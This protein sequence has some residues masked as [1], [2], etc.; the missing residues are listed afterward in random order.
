MKPEPISR[1]SAELPVLKILDVVAQSGVS[2][3]LVHHYR[4]LGLLPEGGS[5]GRYSQRQADLL[6]HVRVLREE[7]QL[8]LEDIRR[9]FEAFDFDPARLEAVTCSVSLLQRAVAFGRDGEVFPEE[10]L[11][12]EALA[13]R[14][15]V[16]VPDA[17][18]LVEQGVVLPVV[19]DSET[20]FSPYDVDTLRLCAAGRRNGVPLSSFRTIASFVRIGVELERRQLFAPLGEGGPGRR[21]LADV[22]ARRELSTNFVISVLHSAAHSAYLR[23]SGPLRPPEAALVELLYRPSDLFVRRHGLERRIERA[24]ADLA[25]QTELGPAWG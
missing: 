13:V 4:R 17:E 7:H 20:R 1:E 23:L 14:A 18:R 22:F 19:E 11:T 3:E 16:S 6:V 12:V 25:D 10:L 5:R 21:E 9:I 15:G 24:R 8:P 2:K